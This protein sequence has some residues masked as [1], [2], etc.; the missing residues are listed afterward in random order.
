M[1]SNPWLQ[2]LSSRL[3]A[4][5]SLENARRFRLWLLALVSVLSIGYA[6]KDLGRFEDRS[7]LVG[8]KNF[9]LV[10]FHLVL[11]SF[12]Y[13][14][15]LLQK[16]EK[17][18]AKLF[19]I[20]DFLT[21]T[22]FSLVFTFSSYVAFVLSWQNATGFE[23]FGASPVF[24]LTVWVNL[25]VAAVYFFGLLFYFASLLFFP[26][27]L[28][29]FAE[30]SGKWP[31]I[32]LTTHG[33]LVALQM[34]TFSE[35]SPF[36]SIVFFEQLQIAALFWIFSLS[37]FLFLGRVLEESKVPALAALELDVASGRLNRE[38]DILA[39]LKEAFALKGLL[40][41]THR[42]SYQASA[43]THEIARFAHDAVNLV[44]RE[45]PT[46]FDLRQVEDRHRRG[47]Q[48]FK[49]LENENQRFLVSVSFFDL[50]ELERERVEALRDQFSRDLRNAKIE[51][52]SVRKKI[53]EKLVGLPPLISSEVPS[54]E[55][56]PLSR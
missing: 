23:G 54:E 7:F 47:E 32:G 40:A 34:L 2:F 4:Q 55:T 14:P 41:W 53:D 6:L 39:R 19:G 33:V 49:R 56:A 31:V 26:S 3:S 11:I 18:I 35:I 22:V 37:A 8:V 5:I 12:Y 29:K 46:E 20:K 25:L 13:L 27:A 44:D 30:R 43:K 28:V 10:F 42:I 17:P 38:E 16:G 1:N 50:S 15:S 45:S 9:Y 24:A 36:G 21:L 52:A 48:I 51:L